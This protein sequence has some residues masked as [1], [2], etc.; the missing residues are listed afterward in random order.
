[1]KSFIQRAVV[2]LG[3]GAVQL[4]GAAAAV[5]AAA[6]SAAKCCDILEKSFP[7]KTYS[8]TDQQNLYQKFVAS[9]FS[10]NDRLTPS[11]AIS[12]ANTNDVAEITGLLSKNSCQFAVKS[13]GH[14]ILTGSSNIVKGVT[15]DL[16]GMRNVSLNKQTKTATVQPG[17]KWIDVYSYMDGLGYA[18]PGGRAGDV[19]VGGLTSGGGNSFF[20]ARYGFAC[21]NVKRFE[22]VLGNGTVVQAT[23]RTNADLFTALKGS[24]NN[25]GI[26]TELDFVAFEQ[27]DLWGGT[28]IYDKKTVPAQIKAFYEFTKNLKNDPYGSLIFV[29]SH[30]PK[31]PKESDRLVILNLY[32]Y[33]AN[34]TGPVTTYPSPF[35]GFAPDS[36]IGPPI[37]NT[38]RIANLSSLTAELNSPAELSNLYATL[39]FANNLTV[40]NEVV[41]ILNKELDY[42]KKDPFYEY[43]SILL[44]PLP[45]LFT[46]RSIERGGNVLGLDRYQDDNVLFLLDM[47]WNGTQY[48]ARI[49]SLADKV[50]GDLTTYLSEVKAL[51]DFQYINCMKRSV[52]AVYNK[53]AFEDQDPLGGY[54]PAALAKI[55]AAS[56]KYDAGQ[57]FQKLVPGGYKLAGA[58]SGN[59]YNH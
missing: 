50:I 55:K 40:L 52:N 12:P 22:V 29:W 20:A 21:D 38:L 27:S 23:N 13:G 6:S 45:R 10:V 9:Y 14:G 46:E 43:A 15:V 19:G 56:K 37:T 18:V 41:R 16:R 33:T 25:L 26:I 32:E 5:D 8:S 47:A 59:K 7:Q 17:A 34:L 51:K 1:M 31:I 58:G 11:C 36:P 24:Q 48:D 28:A 39:T 49:R 42:Y 30:F 44:Q 4:G 54:G 3:C 35:K 57:V 53:H 2:V